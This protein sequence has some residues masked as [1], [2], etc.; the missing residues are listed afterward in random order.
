MANLYIKRLNL[1]ILQQS[2]YKSFESSHY[3]QMTTVL[4]PKISGNCFEKKIFS[5]TFYFFRNKNKPKIMTYLNPNSFLGQL[6]DEVFIGSKISQ[7]LLSK[8]R[9][10]SWKDTT[11]L[12][13]GG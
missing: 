12:L 9:I 3:S 1:S 8:F 4:V 10:I 7:H 11:T 5:P 2:F 6:R 13:D